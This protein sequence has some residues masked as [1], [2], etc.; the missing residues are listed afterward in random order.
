MRFPKGEIYEANVYVTVQRH[1]TPIAVWGVTRCRCLLR[2]AT[3]LYTSRWASDLAFTN[4]RDKREIGQLVILSCLDRYSSQETVNFDEMHN[5]DGFCHSYES[6]NIKSRHDLF[7]NGIHIKEDLFLYEL[8]LCS[9]APNQAMN[10][11]TILISFNRNFN[12]SFIIFHR[13][14]FFQHSDK[15]LF[16]IPFRKALLNFV[17]IS[18][19]EQ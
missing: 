9:Y 11:I 2:D 17:H 4:K 7:T 19:Q 16:L 3:G 10:C 5:Y 6:H 8:T 15:N 13:I 1:S 14:L 18:T 12:P